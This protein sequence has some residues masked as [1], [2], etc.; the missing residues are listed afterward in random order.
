MKKTVTLGMI[1]LVSSLMM[2]G[3][4]AQVPTPSTIENE[5]VK[6][7]LN[8]ELGQKKI[9]KII[10]EVVQAEGWQVTEFKKNEVLAEKTKNE[11]SI[12]VSIRFDNSSF[13]ITPQNSEL[14]DVIFEALS[15]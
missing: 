3:C 4:G 13:E 15:K 9:H 7:T 14:N 11:D 5:G 1:L 8:K 12:A 6:T 2:S 10:T